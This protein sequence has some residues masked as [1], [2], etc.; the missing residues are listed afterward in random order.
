VKGRDQWRGRGGLT[1]AGPTP[2]L[3]V[4]SV[5]CVWGPATRPQLGRRLASRGVQGARARERG[6]QQKLSGGRTARWRPHRKKVGGRVAQHAP[7]PPL[8]VCS[9]VGLA[10][11][12]GAPCEAREVSIF[13]CNS[14]THTRWSVCKVPAFGRPI[15]SLDLSGMCENGESEC[16]SLCAREHAARKVL[17]TLALF[18]CGAPGVPPGVLGRPIL[19]GLSPRA[20]DP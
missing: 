20:S 4:C 14:H 16:S 12:P 5:F 7:Q 3:E 9:G 11:H 18:L 8:P 2:C 15:R 17:S 6:L 1:T 10:P 13:F 19:D